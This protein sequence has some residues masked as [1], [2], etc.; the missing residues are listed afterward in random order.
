[1]LLKIIGIVAVL[2]II[3]AAIFLYPVIKELWNAYRR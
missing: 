2:A 3:G 1:M